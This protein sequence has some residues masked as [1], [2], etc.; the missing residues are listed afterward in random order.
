MEKLYDLSIK[1]A[2]MYSNNTEMNLLIHLRP[3]IQNEFPDVVMAHTEHKRRGRALQAK[4]EDDLA[5]GV[6]VAI[7]EI[8][9]TL[10]KRRA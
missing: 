6:C 3:W 4:E 2:E 1:W 5:K 9:V 8:V 10:S 7:G